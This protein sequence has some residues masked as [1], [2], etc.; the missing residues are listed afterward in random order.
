MCQSSVVDGGLRILL[1]G[2]IGAGKSIA[3]RRFADRGFTV[4]EADRIGHEMLEPDGAAFDAVV[5]RWPEVLFSG[6]I[7]RSR[8]AAIVFADADQLAELERMSHPHI[9]RRIAQYRAEFPRLLVE[10]PVPLE[11]EGDWTRVYLSAPRALR[12]DRAIARGSV[13]HD[14]EQR[15]ARQAGDDTWVEWADETVT[16]DGTIADLDRA[17]DALLCRLQ[18]TGRGRESS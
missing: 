7:D 17:I 5:A 13:R 3:G 6:R 8:L 16:N 1:G 12:R 9:I 10:V 15:M 14:V 2:G 11:P 4:V 18:S